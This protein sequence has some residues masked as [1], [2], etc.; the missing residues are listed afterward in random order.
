[1]DS[2][3]RYYIASLICDYVIRKHITRVE[4]S[5]R[6]I[7]RFHHLKGE[8]CRSISALMNFLYSNHIR[9]PGFGFYIMGTAAFSKSEY[10][11][12]FTIELID[13]ARGL[14]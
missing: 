12:R 10:P 3:K 7:A 5:A 8:S 2:E 4:A 14:L 6:D 13:G 9:K 11:H 1:M